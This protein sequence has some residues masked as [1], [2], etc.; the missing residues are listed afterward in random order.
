MG[1]W[2]GKTNTMKEAMTK[3]DHTIKE[4]VAQV[5]KYPFAVWPERGIRPE[6]FEHFGVRMSV[7]EA[8]GR[9]PTAVYYPYYDQKGKISGYKKRDLTLDK[10]DDFHFT[11]VGKVK[12]TCKLF[13]QQEAESLQQKKTKVIFTE[14]ENDVLAVFQACADSVAGNEKY[15]HLRP[16]VV[17]L[18]LGCGNASSATAH[19]LKFLTQYDKVTLAFDNDAA[20]P[21]EYAKGIRR[22]KEATEV[23]ATQLTGS[24]DIFLTEFPAEVK[25]ANDWL[26]EDSKALASAVSFADKKYVAEKV[27]LSSELSFDDLMKPKPRGVQL[28]WCPEFMEKTGGPRKRELWVVTGPSGG[29]KSTV[30]SAIAHDI[31]VE[32]NRVAY[33]ALEE[34]KTETAQRM[35]AAH[36]RV[37]FNT[38]K[39]DPKAV[40][41]SVEEQRKAFEWIQEDDR[42][43]FL[44]HFGSLP[45][46]ELISKLKYLLHA[47]KV[48]YVML[49][50][51]SMMV[52]GIETTD[53]RKLLDLTMT[54]LAAFCASND[55]GIIAVSHL[56]RGI[57]QEF[58]APKGEEDKPFWVHV[59]KEDLRGSASLE[60]LSWVVV[61][62]EQEILPDRTRGR[63]RLVVLKNRPWGSLGECDVLR[64]NSRT[65][66][67]E[68]A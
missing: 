62:V 20:S 40:D 34:T 11:V 44:D 26:L 3:H 36:I 22:G 41:V 43:V 38:Y 64:M 6:V 35:L 42:F 17:G 8:D 52:S 59:R 37:N 32:G 67:L 49:D 7:S 39:H 61:G 51:L 28:S 27:V 21:Q 46:K 30:V 47:L 29:G 57:A 25:D 63:V 13:G 54:E 2:N 16:A 66:E 55:M 14:G 53:E 65:G 45:V 50:H 31:A 58:K 23:V 60:Q 9:T 12:E 10:D 68:A 5:S 56:N 1:Y 33:I 15:K 24:V 4:T 18:T 48:D 19:N